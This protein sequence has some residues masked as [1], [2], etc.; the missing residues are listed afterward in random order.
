M[1][2]LMCKKIETYRGDLTLFIYG[3]LTY[4][5]S[6]CSLC[7]TENKGYSIVKNGTKE[8]TIKW[9]PLTHTS[10]YFILKKQRF[11]CRNC[12]HTFI[13]SFIYMDAQTH[14]ILD[15]LPNRQLHALRS[16]FSQFPLS[17]RKQV[18]SVAI[19]M[20]APYFVVIQELFPN[21][22]TIIDRFHIVQLMTRSLNQT[23]IRVMKKFNH[24]TSYDQKGLH[25]IKSI[26]ALDFT[27]F[28]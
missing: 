27:R 13:M 8:C 19:D 3:T 16:Y 28:Q 7:G 23:R 2:C 12:F 10:T 5:P 9:L 15:I 1:N 18:Q 14:E 6:H 22:K 26:L 17:V 25:K 11:F 21:A 24:S 20:N 4:T